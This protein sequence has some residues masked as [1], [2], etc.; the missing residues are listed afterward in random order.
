MCEAG[1]RYQP[2]PAQSS[3][4]P[5]FLPSLPGGMSHIP[6]REA[7]GPPLALGRARL[8]KA[9]VGHPPHLM[10]FSNASFSFRR[11]VR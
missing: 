5:F 9:P 8:S 6:A 2:S 4:L 7:T 3:P 11:A 10:S 1:P